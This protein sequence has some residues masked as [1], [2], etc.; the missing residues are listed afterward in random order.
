MIIKTIGRYMITL[1]EIY[2]HGKKITNIVVY[3]FDGEIAVNHGK[4][5]GE[6]YFHGRIVECK[7]NEKEIEYF[8]SFPR[9]TEFRRGYVVV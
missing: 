6:F 1:H 5:V 9:Y 8:I 7:F 3:E 2:Y 4:P